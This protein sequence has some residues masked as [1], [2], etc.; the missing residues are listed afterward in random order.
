MGYRE[1]TLLSVSDKVVWEILSRVSTNHNIAFIWKVS[2]FP[3]ERDVI[4]CAAGR[5]LVLGDKKKYRSV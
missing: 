3:K 2:S 1:R 4:I 5:I